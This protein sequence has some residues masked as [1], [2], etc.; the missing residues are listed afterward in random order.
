MTIR[1]NDDEAEKLVLARGLITP[2]KLAPYRVQASVDSSMLF[3]IL[4]TEG[5]ITPELV[6][7]LEKSAPP[8]PPPRSLTGRPT[9]FLQRPTAPVGTPPPPPPSSAG[10]AA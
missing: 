9:G 5:V 2:D 3:D 4:V 8:P 10:L 7:E 6:A 1:L